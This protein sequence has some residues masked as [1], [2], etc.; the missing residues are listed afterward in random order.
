MITAFWL[1]VIVLFFIL[2][3]MT[4]NLIT[5]WFAV[6]G[7]AAL[8]TSYFKTNFI[9]QGNSF[10][11]VT[12]ISLEATRPSIKKYLKVKSVRTNLDPVVGKEGVVIVPIQTDDLGRLHLAG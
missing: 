2:E 9:I 11:T 6:G 4:F 5:I 7:I 12:V 8:I 3:A 1:I 10:V